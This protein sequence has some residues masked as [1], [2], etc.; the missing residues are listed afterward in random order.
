MPWG[1]RAGVLHDNNTKG[2]YVSGGIGM[3]SLKWSIDLAARREVVNG[4]E[5]ILMAS[6]RFYGPREPS[7]ARQ[8]SSGVMSASSDASPMSF[9]CST[10]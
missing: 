6:M 7:P 3:A 1:L 2:T 8:N 5:T 10:I 4:N 9:A